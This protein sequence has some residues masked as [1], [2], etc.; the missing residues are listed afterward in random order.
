M[1]QNLSGRNTRVLMGLVSAELLRSNSASG[2]L[3]PPVD[4][5]VTTTAAKPWAT[6][7]DIAAGFQSLA[8]TALTGPLPKGAVLALRSG[9]RIRRVT[10]AQHVATGAVSVPVLPIIPSDL[11]STAALLLLNAVPSGAVATHKGLFQLRGGKKADLSIKAEDESVQV[12]TDLLIGEIDTGTS[13]YKT[14]TIK[15]KEGEIPLEGLVDPDD[16]GYMMLGNAATSGQSAYV[17]TRLVLPP[18]EG[19][20]IGESYEGLAEL[21][22]WDVMASADAMVSFKT[23]VKFRNAIKRTNALETMSA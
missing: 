3:V 23:Q 6:P 18:G 10:V 8:V 22:G 1:G 14:G 5:T 4:V 15:S 12:F 7:A 16:I 21:V 2:L 13:G 20:D 11:S 19:Y 17:F 9:A